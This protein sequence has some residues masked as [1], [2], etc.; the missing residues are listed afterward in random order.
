MYGQ[1]TS[2][3]K[4][5][6]SQTD[7]SSHRLL[8]ITI[9]EVDPDASTENQDDNVDDDGRRTKPRT[10]I[11]HRSTG[12]HVTRHE[13]FKEFLARVS[14]AS[15]SSQR[16][17]SGGSQH[18]RSAVPSAGST[19]IGQ[20]TITGSSSSSS[21]TAPAIAKEKAKA[22]PNEALTSWTARDEYHLSQEDEDDMR[23]FN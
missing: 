5:R 7:E 19:S 4:E 12:G 15:Q 3:K 1:G 10:G 22:N 16:Q 23:H 18:T 21:Q 11:R 13:K 6:V 9:S 14:N 2:S 8:T 20:T 17:Y